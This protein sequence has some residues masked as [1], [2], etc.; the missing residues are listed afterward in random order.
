MGIG[1]PT[2]KDK[3]TIMKFLKPRVRAK[4]DGRVVNETLASMFRYG[5]IG[6]GGFSAPDLPVWRAERQAGWGSIIKGCGA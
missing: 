3:G 4:A 5:K 1:N 6:P 2:A